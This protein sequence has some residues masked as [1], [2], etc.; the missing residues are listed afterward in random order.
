MS[1][2]KCQI[3]SEASLTSLYKII[4]LWAGT[5]FPYSAI[6]VSAY[7]HSR[8]SRQTVDKWAFLVY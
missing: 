8:G 2:L 7:M 4:T 1:L 6:K 5:L 3:I